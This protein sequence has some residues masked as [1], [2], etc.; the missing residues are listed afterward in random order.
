MDFRY[1]FFLSHA[2]EDLPHAERLS[3]LL[4]GDRS[5]F[6]DATHLAAGTRWQPELER[7]LIASRCVVVLLSPQG[8]N[9]YYVREEI[10]IAVN[11][12][13]ATNGACSIVCVL[14]PSMFEPERWKGTLP[15]GTN[16]LQHLKCKR[17]DDLTSVAAT[18]RGT[19]ASEA[20][21]PAVPD[22][23]AS[24]PSIIKKIIDAGEQPPRHPLLAY[25]AG[26]MVPAYVLA[27]LSQP[28]ANF[29]VGPSDAL[30]VLDLAANYRQRA[31]PGARVLKRSEVLPP[32]SVRPSE[33]WFNTLA[34]AG[35]FGPRMVAA[36][37][38][39]IQ[40]A[41]ENQLDADAHQ[42]I[43]EVQTRLMTWQ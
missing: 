7:A 36:L 23:D 9:K 25:P 43:A 17:D 16:Q 39:V 8:L 12:M 29:F 1:D 38:E 21:T 19:A 35:K 34:D 14:L 5:V 40:S 31:E 6:L 28:I 22:A 13:I 42:R 4:N 3:R 32:A 24:P 18:L 27:G 11:Q 2:S 20:K 10:C 41:S 37:L 15:F 33:W 30:A 26:P